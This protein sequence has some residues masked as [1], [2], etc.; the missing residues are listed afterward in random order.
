MDNPLV[1]LVAAQKQGRAVGIHSVCSANRFV[2]EAAML[3]AKT[4]E[5]IP[6]L[7]PASQAHSYLT[8]QAD[9]SFLLIEATSN[10]VNQEGGYT[11]M[12][13]KAFVAYVKGIAQ[14]MEFPFHRL[15]LGG[16]HLGPHA[17]QGETAAA[18]MA[19]ARELVRACVLAGFQK[20]HLDTSMRCADDPSDDR[21]SLPMELAVE[22]AAQLCRVCEAVYADRPSDSDPPIYV[23]GTEVPPP[24]GA[25]KLERVSPTQVPDAERTIELTHQAFL[26]SGLSAAWNRVIAVVVQPG[27]E[28]GDD[29]VIPY[30]RSQ[31]AALTK[32]IESHNN[33]IYEAHSTDYQSR[34]T[35]RQ[36]VEDH[37]AILKVG[38][39]LTFAFREAVFALEHIEIEWLSRKKSVQRS[40]LREVVEQAMRARPRHW[41]KHYHGDEDDLSFA[42]WFSYSDR[43]R[44]YWN[45]PEVAAALH[46]LLANVAE[47]PAPMTLLSQYL[48]R[49][50]WAVRE[51][52]IANTPADLIHHKIR[53]V[54][55]VYVYAT[56]SRN[57]AIN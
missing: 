44:Y 52:R 49:Q 21:G 47:N 27:V 17:W 43:I 38:P 16:D 53:E 36:L 14:K 35:L 24:G 9:R 40:R 15:M 4:R 8:C 39:W 46:L 33:L 12:T 37:F 7:N 23:I 31:S 42:R 10:Q 57:G 11:G 50:Y 18:A 32:F 22:R 48:P 3:Q 25:E 1:Q 41:Q 5:I 29:A 20:I 54:L 55:E 13:P 30:N 34:E 51:G 26:S 6:Y 19:K 2:L 28:F 56:K 45:E